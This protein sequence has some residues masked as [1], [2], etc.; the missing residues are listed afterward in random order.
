MDFDEVLK[1]QLKICSVKRKI[2]LSHLE[3]RKTQT[4]TSIDKEISLY[5]I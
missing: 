2:T 4:D 5:N 3:F 1:K